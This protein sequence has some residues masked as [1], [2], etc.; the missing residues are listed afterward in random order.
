MLLFVPASVKIGAFA[1]NLCLT[2]CLTIWTVSHLYS[3]I[4]LC[5]RTLLNA[6]LNYIKRLHRRSIYCFESET[7]IITVA[8][9]LGSTSTACLKFIRVKN[10]KEFPRWQ[11]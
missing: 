3:I 5:T 7:K 2:I 1:I 9:S 10:E 4:Y 6:L 8:T 11:P